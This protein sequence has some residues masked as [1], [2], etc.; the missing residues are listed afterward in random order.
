MKKSLLTY[1]V[2]SMV[3]TLNLKYL[4]GTLDLNDSE[5]VNSWLKTTRINGLAPVTK[6]TSK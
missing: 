2:V 1:M 5:Q 6:T 3:P 4:A